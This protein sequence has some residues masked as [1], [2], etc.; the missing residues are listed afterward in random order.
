MYPL[1][2]NEWILRGELIFVDN[3]SVKKYFASNF[4]GVFSLL[5][6]DDCIELAKLRL[7]T[8]FNMASKPTRG[9]RDSSDDED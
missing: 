6:R 9:D 4:H 3:V 8:W 1:N 5:P 2:T 7:V